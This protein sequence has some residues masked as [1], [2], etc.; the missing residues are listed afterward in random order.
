MTMWRDVAIFWADLQ[1]D[2]RKL[3]FAAMD[4][5]VFV[6]GGVVYGWAMLLCLQDNRCC[7]DKLPSNGGAP[8]WCVFK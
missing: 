3:L 8:L 7:F 5:A 4:Y 1:A 6:L 2:Y